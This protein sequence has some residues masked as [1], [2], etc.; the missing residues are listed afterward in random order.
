MPGMNIGENTNLPQVVCPVSR[1][2]TSFPLDNQE[3]VRDN[4][5]VASPKNL[6]VFI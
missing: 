3:K 5:R 6:T 4:Y 1:T 2:W